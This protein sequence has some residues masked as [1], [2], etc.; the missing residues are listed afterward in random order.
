MTISECIISLS[1]KHRF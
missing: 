1:L